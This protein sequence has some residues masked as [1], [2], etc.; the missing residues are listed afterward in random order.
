MEYSSSYLLFEV[1]VEWC[2]KD[3]N[4]VCI[5]SVEK[6]LYHFFKR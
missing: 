3:P 5:E 6:S 2:I 4:Q 1:I